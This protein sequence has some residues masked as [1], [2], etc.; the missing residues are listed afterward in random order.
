MDQPQHSV[1]RASLLDT[2]KA[3]SASFFGVRGSRNHE[4]DMSTL[5]P[6]AVIGVGLALAA[7]FVAVLVF[8]VR[9]AVSR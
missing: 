8:V 1:R 6:I 7:V 9:F 4:R 2:V 5:N 3:V